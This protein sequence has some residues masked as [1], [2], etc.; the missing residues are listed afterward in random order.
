MFI[1]P[2]RQYS[3]HPTLSSANTSTVA[4][5]RWSAPSNHLR[6]CL[7]FS[8]VTSRPV[9]ISFAIRHLVF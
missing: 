9:T 8:K 2:D 5:F 7:Q 1:E 6:Y 4:R 3:R